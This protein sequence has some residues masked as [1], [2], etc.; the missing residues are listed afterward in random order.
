MPFNQLL[1]KSKNF[2][3]KGNN[4]KKLK[5]QTFRKYKNL[6]KFFNINS[7]KITFYQQYLFK[8]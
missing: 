8:K 4:K 7:S 3:L 6:M 2:A 1:I 5:S